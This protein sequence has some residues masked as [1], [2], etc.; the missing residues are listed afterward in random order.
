[1]IPIRQKPKNKNPKNLRIPMNKI[2]VLSMLVGLA[3]SSAALASGRLLSHKGAPAKSAS[4]QG[5]KEVRYTMNPMN[6]R[7]PRLSKLVISRDS[8]GHIASVKRQ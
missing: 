1:M 5:A 8:S 4:L 2:L 6:G 7:G 3:T